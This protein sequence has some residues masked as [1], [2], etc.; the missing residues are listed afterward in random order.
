[1]IIINVSWAAKQ[2]IRMLSEGSCDDENWCNDADN[3]ALASQESII[4][5][6]K[7]KKQLSKS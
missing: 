4:F 2:Y 7:K 3:V 1:M 5:Y 6:R